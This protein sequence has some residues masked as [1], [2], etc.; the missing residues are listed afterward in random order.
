M[1]ITPGHGAIRFNDE[2][3][4]FAAPTEMDVDPEREQQLKDLSKTMQRSGLQESRMAAFQFEPVSLPPSRVRLYQDSL[5]QYPKQLTLDRHHRHPVQG[6][7]L[8]THHHG[9]HNH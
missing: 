5:I 7:I 4:E 8:V 2:T 9:G 3:E 1:S 6:R